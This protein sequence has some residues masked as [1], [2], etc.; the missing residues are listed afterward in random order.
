[1]KTI[2]FILICFVGLT[3]TVSG[4]LMI[5]KPNGDIM[6]LSLSLLE[7]TPFTNYLIPGIVLAILVGAVN[8]VAVFFNIQRNANRY[9]WA[10]AGGV[11]I[12][13][14]IIAQMILIQTAH[15]LHFL[16]LGIGVLIIL[17]AYQLKGKWAA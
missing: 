15:W 1:M 9:N 11:M 17:L 5:S 12:S 2:L 16:Y 8:L 14:W 4:L 7:P 10:I 13:G 3:A 6:G